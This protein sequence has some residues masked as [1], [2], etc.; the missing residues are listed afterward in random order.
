M[1]QRPSTVEGRL[2]V[3]ANPSAPV[4]TIGGQHIDVSQNVKN[5]TFTVTNQPTII[6]DIY[7]L[8]RNANLSC[9]A[10]GP[11]SMTQHGLSYASIVCK[12]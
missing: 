8:S 2:A 5:G 11:S 10:S 12:N 7:A 4:V 1:G 9:V 6:K 3:T